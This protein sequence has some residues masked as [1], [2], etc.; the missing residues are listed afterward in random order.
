MKSSYEQ[1]G[2][3]GRCRNIDGILVIFKWDIQGVWLGNRWEVLVKIVENIGIS[4]N[5]MI[6]V[7]ESNEI[8]K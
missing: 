5:T 6:L 3:I 7:T 2:W 8:L 4:I 1:R